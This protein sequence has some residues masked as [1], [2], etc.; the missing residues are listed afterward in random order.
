MEL[1]RV[2]KVW[3]DEAHCLVDMAFIDLNLM[4]ICAS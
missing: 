2:N 1:Y 3:V 4:K